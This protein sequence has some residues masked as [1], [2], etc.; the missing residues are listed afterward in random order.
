[1]P[2]A[3]DIVGWPC[4]LDASLSID[5]GPPVSMASTLRTTDLARKSCIP[6]R[7]SLSGMITKEIQPKSIF[8]TNRA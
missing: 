7:Q 6:L 2:I 1:M 4:H 8:V 5:A 3:A